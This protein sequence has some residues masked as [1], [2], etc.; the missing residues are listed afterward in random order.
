MED[1]DD[2]GVPLFGDVDLDTDWYRVPEWL[3][4]LYWEKLYLRSL[5]LPYIKKWE[6]QLS[7]LEEMRLWERGWHWMQ[8]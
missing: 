7:R 6:T 2:P 5:L 8:D 4:E 1:Y 3:K